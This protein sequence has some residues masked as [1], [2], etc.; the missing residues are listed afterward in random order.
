MVILYIVSLPRKTLMH[1]WLVPP[2]RG[3][4]TRISVLG[5]FLADLICSFSGLCSRV[6]YLRE[7]Q[8]GGISGGSGGHAEYRMYLG[9]VRASLVRGLL[10]YRVQSTL[11]TNKRTS[12]LAI[13][14]DG[15]DWM[16]I[17]YRT[18]QSVK[19]FISLFPYISPLL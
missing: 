1:V 2:I 9:T 16:A 8:S 14:L 6:L 7:Q 13:V 17:Q 12:S 5:W 19:A 15:P 4:G 3:I 10:Q 18:G 11:A